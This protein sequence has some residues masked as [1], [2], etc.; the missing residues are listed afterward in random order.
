MVEVEV[1]EAVYRQAQEVV[2][3]G[4][5]GFFSRLIAKVLLGRVKAHVY[6]GAI[7]A[8]EGV[9]LAKRIAVKTFNGRR[10]SWRQGSYRAVY[11]EAIKHV[12]DGRLPP[13]NREK[14]LELL[15]MLN[16]QVTAG[17]IPKKKGVGL[18]HEIVVSSFSAQCPEYLAKTD[19]LEFTWEM[20][21]D[22]L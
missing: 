9:E 18:A 21:K 10:W 7:G 14:A 16:N 17:E 12:S 20:L 4:E 11:Q 2:E 15:A 6:G 3:H 13:G 5:A 19:T 1:F 22:A 8:D